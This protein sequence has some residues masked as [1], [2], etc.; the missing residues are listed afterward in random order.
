MGGRARWP[1]LSAAIGRRS[2]R[3]LGYLT[4]IGLAFVDPLISIAI[5]VVIAA[6]WLV[7]DPRIE[8]QHIAEHRAPDKDRPEAND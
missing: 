5:Y 3:R 6:A 2:S 4:A 7:P 8:R 1:W